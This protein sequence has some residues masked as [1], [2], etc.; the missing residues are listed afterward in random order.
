ME[1]ITFFVAPKNSTFVDNGKVGESKFGHVFIGATKFDPVTHTYKTMSLGFSPGDNWGTASDNIS[2]NDHIRYKDASSLTLLSMNNSDLVH[3]FSA[4]Y[5]GLKSGKIKPET[6]SLIGNN[7][8]GFVNK[9]ANSLGIPL[10]LAIT[11][12]KILENLQHIADNYLTPLVIDLDGDGISTID[13]DLMF[14]FSGKGDFYKTGWINKN[15]AFLVIDKNQD[16]NISGN[17]LFGGYS[18]L[19]DGSYAKDGFNA[20]SI[21]DSNNDGKINQEDESWENLKLWIDKNSDKVSQ[22]DEIYSLNQ[23][24]IKEISLKET[25]IRTFDEHGNFHQTKSE[26]LLENGK[27]IEMV[28][29]FFRENSI[30]DNSESNDRDSSISAS[31]YTYNNVIDVI[32]NNY[33]DDTKSEAIL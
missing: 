10:K 14:D 29:V 17:E 8:I 4:I 30:V 16:N 24:S 6:Y 32:P 11:P 33:F 20:L 9:I 23:F 12:D 7:C 5:D 22:L 28:D 13:S 21:Y 3:Q 18:E 25:D 31:E 19:K 2:F 1:S 15:D 27:V 26:I